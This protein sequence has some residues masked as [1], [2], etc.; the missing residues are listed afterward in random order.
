VPWPQACERLLQIA[1][2]RYGSERQHA[3]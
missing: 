1:L 2:E 3:F